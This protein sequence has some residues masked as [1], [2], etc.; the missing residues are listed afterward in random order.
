[1]FKYM[2][3]WISFALN[4]KGVFLYAAQLHSFMTA[5]THRPSLLS[6]L[7]FST[8]DRVISLGP[9]TLDLAPD[10]SPHTRGATWYATKQITSRHIVLVPMVKIVNKT[11]IPWLQQTKNQA[12]STIGR[13]DCWPILE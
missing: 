12:A 10:T 1:M 11:V 3:S 6:L 9:A 8:H 13:T 7:C 5:L 4:T 2:Q